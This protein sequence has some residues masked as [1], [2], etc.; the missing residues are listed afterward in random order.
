MKKYYRWMILLFMLTGF[1]HAAVLAQDARQIKGKVTSNDGPLPGVS[2][3]VKGTTTGTTTDSNGDYSL[4]VEASNASLVFTFVGYVSEE[5]PVEGRSTIDVLLVEDIATLSEVVVVGYGTQSKKNLASAITNVKPEEM[6]KGAITDV[7]QLLQGKIPGVN[8]SAS[9]DP[10]VKAAVIIRGASTLNSSQTP[11]Y[12]IDGIIGADISIVAPD[13]IASIDILKDASATAIYG[14]RASNG[15]IMITTKR[16]KK[17]QTQ[18]TYSSYVGVEKVSHRLKMMDANQ[19]RSF[20]G[21][22]GLALSPADDLGANTDWQKTVEKKSAVSHNHNISFNGGTEHNTYSASVNYSYKDGILPKSSLSRVI[23]RLAMDQYALNDKV[24]FGINLNY[25]TNNATNTPLRNNVL[26]Q[27]IYRLPVSPVRDANGDYFENT[28]TGAYFN[29]MAMIDHAKDETKYTTFVGGFSTQVKLPFGLMYDINVSYQNE[30]SLHGEAYDSYYSKT[31]GGVNFYNNPD[32]PAVHTLL[33]FGTNGTALRNTYQT[34]KKILETYITWDK[35][36]G[37]HTINAVLGYSYQGSE[38]GDGFQVTSTNFAVDNIGYSNFVLSNPYAIPS[39]RINFGN[40]NTYYKTKLISDFFRV[41][42]NYKD[43]YLLQ[44]SVRRDG[45]SVFGA[46]NQWGYFPS[47]GVAWRIIEEGFM[48]TQSIFTDLKLRGSYGVTGNSSGFNA[49]TAQFIMGS[50]GTFY[51]NGQQLA[52][53][54]PVQA[55]NPNL[56][57]EKTATTNIGVDFGLL[58]NKLS[59]SIELY[60]KNTTGM[61]ASYAVNPALVSAGTIVANGGSINNKGIELSLNASPV[62]AGDFT[63]NTGINLAHNTNKIT[64]LSNPLFN[65]GDSITYTRP[66]GQGQTGAT[67]QIFKTGKPLGQFF[68]QHYAGQNEAGKSQYIDKNGNLTTQTGSDNYFYAGSPQPKL[69]MGWTNTFTYKNFTLNVFFRGVFGNKIFNATRA[70]LFRPGTAQYTNVL[71][72]VAG[73][74]ADARA[75]IYSSRFIES[76][77]YVRLDNAT[78]AYN[79][80]LAGNYIKSLR[81][82]TSVNNAFVITKYKGIDP[83]INQGGTALGVDSNN[84]YPK[85]RTFLLGINASF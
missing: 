30:N 70:D 66:E 34:T 4:M 80:K 57:W 67:L 12:V 55:S 85:T 39:Y 31:Y 78:L 51:Y 11:L 83:E 21:E 65:G 28:T 24:K 48:T 61:I 64:S 19:L 60:N 27:M 52:A 6:N 1:S 17:G 20:L 15:V 49:Y 36:L 84:F 13:D 26:Q 82:Y 56:R 68:T 50:Q 76:G 75:Y 8:I 7:A 41:N 16:G 33:N 37:D 40:D 2:V 81:L 79:F 43:K 35:D 9:G 54:G 73:Q 22:S 71:A 59:G 32:P 14:N 18:V 45:S 10:N 63:W 25:S 72:E 62:K 29:P 44:G 69:L 3:L 38:V 53:Y 5:I 77:S 47:V 42:Y 58:D 23:A 46:N 74:Q